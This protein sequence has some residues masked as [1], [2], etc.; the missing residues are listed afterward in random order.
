MKAILLCTVLAVIVLN[1]RAAPTAA[2]GEFVNFEVHPVSGLAVAQSPGGWYRFLLVCNTPDN[3]IYIYRIG[4]G[5][6]NNDFLE[7]VQ[8]VPVGLAPVSV[9]YVQDEKAFY[10]ANYIGDSVTKVDFPS[11][12]PPLVDVFLARVNRTVRVGDSPT[13]LAYNSVTDALEVVLS[14]PGQVL[15]L[16]MD[17]LEQLPFAG[18]VA[19]PD[20]LGFDDR[21]FNFA[22]LD[23]MKE[24]RRILYGADDRKHVLALRGDNGFDPESPRLSALY[25]DNGGFGFDLY[26]INYSVASRQASFQRNPFGSI[27]LGLA[28]AGDDLFVTSGE[29]RN[30]RPGKAAHRAA[31]LG[32]TSTW[33]PTGFVESRL[34]R[35]TSTGGVFGPVSL[36]DL[37]RAPN[38]TPVPPTDRVSMPTDVAVRVGSD[39]DA[40]EV[41]VASFGTDRII[42]LDASG[43]GTPAS[44][45]NQ[46]ITLP[47]PRPGYGMA[48]P[49]SLLVFGDRL[50]SLNSLD[51]TVHAYS[52]LPVG[53]IVPSTTLITVELL[54]PTPQVI[55]DGRHFLYD[56]RLSQGQMS[57]CASCHVDGRVDGLTWDLNDPEGA[58]DMS[59]PFPILVDAAVGLSNPPQFP[60]RK[61]LKTTQTLQGLVTH[62]VEGGTGGAQEL[63]TGKPYHWR[64]DKR[65]FT[66]FNE[67]FVTLLGT[68]DLNPGGDPIGLDPNLEMLQFR[69]FINT[70]MFPP[71]PEQALHRKYRGDLGNPNSL[72]AG[73]GSGE[74]RGLKLFHGR[75]IT[76]G[77]ASRL[78]A[79]RSCVQCHSLPGGSNNR[80]SLADGAIGGLGPPGMDPE[81]PTLQP[82]DTPGLRGLSIREGN[83]P[84]TSTGTFQLPSGNSGLLQDGS[85]SRNI[86]QFI[87]FAFS[88][89]FPGGASDE[90]DVA[91]FVRAFDSGIAPIIGDSETWVRG[92]NFIPPQPPAATGAYPVGSR[93]GVL[94]QQARRGNAGLVVYRQTGIPESVVSFVRGYYYDASTDRYMSADGSEP[95]K[96][97]TQLVF[98]GPPFDVM[99]FT[100]VPLGSERRIANLD[101]AAVGSNPQN[102][103]PSGVVLEPMTPPSQWEEVPLL[104]HNTQ[105]PGI[106]N[107]GPPFLY[108]GLVNPTLVIPDSLVATWSLQYKLID[109][110]AGLNYGLTEQAHGA[111]RRLRVTGD[112]ILPGARLHLYLPRSQSSWPVQAGAQLTPANSFELALDLYPRSEV[113]SGGGTRVVWETSVEVDPMLVLILLNGGPFAP[114]IAELF[115]GGP[116]GLTPGGLQQSLDVLASY[117]GALDPTAWNN[118]YVEVSNEPGP[119]ASTRPRSPLVLAPLTIQ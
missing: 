13:D 3:S 38:G 103:A 54:D 19:I 22:N 44:W 88:G 33:S 84:S 117:I 96:N 55:R 36:R 53:G 41:F 51:N 9:K 60:G 107:S 1:L 12:T 64:G 116:T 32:G 35:L 72:A 56:A 34:Y 28:A 76:A 104:R 11:S 8:R 115:F 80:V 77:T 73:D 99:V 30:D 27:N 78:I 69:D 18:A 37:N 82:L 26:T 74:L 21:V 45:P 20:A 58:P 108:P 4:N 70:I 7:F 59:V 62:P 90:A 39:G 81:P 71:N 111:P 119:N 65:D 48:G 40:D 75:S 112:N 10:T 57:S 15:P 5:N 113:L 24:P 87:E 25:P 23:V 16:D 86:A 106:T 110:N 63:F 17:T 47:P 83:D 79:G 101:G 2:Q 67:A 31:A 66:E 94:E 85:E 29:A 95:P 46:T 52:L 93:L 43:G 6:L 109:L 91:A 98:G 118:Y 14:V 92:E 49:R 42:R 100:A 61:G 97:I 114:G 68:P 89:A 105:H 102:L 50:Y